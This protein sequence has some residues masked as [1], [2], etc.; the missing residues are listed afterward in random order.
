MRQVFALHPGAHDNETILAGVRQALG[1]VRRRTDHAPHVV[2]RIDDPRHADTWRGDHI[3]AHQLWLEDALS[4]Y[5]TTA[6]FAVRAVLAHRARTLVLCG[7]T[8][9]ALAILIEAAR[10]AWER[11]ELREAAEAG[12]QPGSG[13]GAGFPEILVMADRAADLQREFSATAAPHL[14]AALPEVK[15]AAGHW[16]G[17]LLPYLDTRPPAEAAACVVVITDVPSPGN[18]HEAGRVARLHPGTVIYAQSVDDAGG[19]GVVF[20]RLHH[21][22]RG[23]LVDGALPADTWTRLARH[24]HEC[25]RLRWPVP[26][27]SPRES[28]RR[29]WD[30]LDEFFRAENIRQVRQVLSSAVH[31]GRLWRPLRAVPPGSVVEFTGSELLWIARTEHDRWYKRRIAAGW[32]PPR[33]GEREDNSRRVNASVVSWDALPADI[34]HAN[35]Q[36]IRSI[37][38]RLQTIGYAA[39]LP[40]GGPGHAAGYRRHGEVWAERLVQAGAWTAPDGAVMEAQ[41]GDWRVRDEEGIERTVRDAQFRASHERVDGHRWARTGEVRA[42]RVSEPTT[43]LTLEGPATAAA[44]DWIVQGPGGERWPVPASQFERGHVACPGQPQAA[45][46]E[47]PGPDSSR[48]R[49]GQRGSVTGISGRESGHRRVSPPGQ[50]DEVSRTGS[51]AQ[52]QPHRVSRTGH[53][54]ASERHAGRGHRLPARPG[55]AYRP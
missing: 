14:R 5:E 40:D 21:F 18:T 27:G 53:R 9:L 47:G 23:F 6:V 31:L 19:A 37:L 46:E 1:Q 54:P 39:V 17:Q 41:P 22:R 44:G 11:Q 29:P 38:E 24:N 26:A 28:S 13:P 12:G 7:D 33:A 25:Y 10:S 43:V 52:G 51:A 49:F 48:S 42:W 4:P 3:G 16:R 50:P 15:I 2:A 55:R 36:H 8:T 34:R 20:D 35:V 30:D 32:H 45:G